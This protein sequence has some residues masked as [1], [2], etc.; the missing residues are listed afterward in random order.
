M[1]KSLDSPRGGG[2]SSNPETLTR[3]E[4]RLPKSKKSSKVT[5]LRELLDEEIREIGEEITRRIQTAR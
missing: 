2:E 4:N 5:Q 1:R 3:K